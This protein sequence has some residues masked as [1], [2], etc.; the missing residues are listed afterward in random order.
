MWWLVLGL[1]VGILIL[2]LL[3]TGRPALGTAVRAAALFENLDRH[4]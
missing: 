4:R 1:G 2:A 3:S